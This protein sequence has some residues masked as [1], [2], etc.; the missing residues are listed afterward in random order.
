MAPPDDSDRVETSDRAETSNRVEPSGRAVAAP[1]A[2]SAGRREFAF[3]AA[4]GSVPALGAHVVVEAP[5][6]SCFLGQVRDVEV[7]GAPAGH[8]ARG[9]GALLA[10]SDG[11]EFAPVGL[12][13]S[14]D[15]AAVRLAP[16]ELVS[17]WTA[18]ALGRGAALEVG[19]AQDDPSRPVRLAAAGFARHT[20]LCGQS[21]SGKTYTLGLLLER[22]LL[23]TRLPLVMLDPNSDYVRL[24]ELA[25]G[26][27]D[28]AGD[29]S[30]LARRIV[31][32]RSGGEGPRLQIRF[33]RLPLDMQALVLGLDPVRDAE[34]Y[35]VL[36]R[37][38]DA[39]GTSEYALADIRARLERAPGGADRRLRLRV[40]NL[41]V[42]GWRVW[43]GRDDL[44]LLEQAPVGWRAAVLDLG[45]LPTA[46]ERST[47]AAATLAELWSRRHARQPVL[48]V[49]DEAH[50]VCPQQPSDSTQRLAVDLAV[51][52]AGEG[53]KYGIYLLLATQRPQKLHAN[54]LSQCE[55]LV[56]M[57]VASAADRAHL[58][59]TFSQVPPSLIALSG[60]FGLGEG[61]AAGR[62][63]P[64]PVLFRTGRR[65]SPEGGADVPTTWANARA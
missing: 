41:G 64:S 30:D 62:I 43:A 29:V 16:H 24:G 5:D 18:Q 7:V 58:A 39:M 34:E 63:A 9:A 40:D 3:E 60:G 36:R 48:V 8:R 12:A 46:A 45:S 1:R 56:L 13:E 23:Q 15:E 37:A 54:V 47:V 50:N 20:F 31:V 33:G 22:L 52:I 61:L 53:R 21:G 42:A 26:G 38:G 32:F 65:L 11:S 57:R 25:S 10:R 55:N 49:V 19:V 35:D 2:W 14:F 51:A 28:D 44:P 59:R 27:L 17:A 6:G 4:L